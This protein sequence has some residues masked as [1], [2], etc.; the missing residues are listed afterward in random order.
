M[1]NFIR[2]LLYFSLIVQTAVAQTGDE[3]F[4]FLRYPTSTRANALGGNN[5]SL[6]ERDPSLIFHNPALLGSEMDGSVVLRAWG[7]GHSRSAAMEQAKKQAVYDVI[8]EGVRKGQCNFKP[9]LFEVNAREKYQAYFDKFFSK[10]GD[11]EQFLK[12]DATKMGSG[13]KAESKTRDSYALVVRVLRADL[14]KKLI[15]DNILEK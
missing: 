9:L 8:F 1:K 6:I 10:G 14:E 3:V 5:V 4:T 2:I 11:Y 12:M 13:V 15:A 7:Q